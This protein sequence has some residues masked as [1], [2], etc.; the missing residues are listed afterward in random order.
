[1]PQ[2]LV[3]AVLAVPQLAS[4]AWPS[5]ALAALR[6]PDEQLGRSAPTGRLLFGR[7]AR[8]KPPILPLP[9]CRHRGLPS[10]MNA[11]WRPAGYNSDGD[12]VIPNPNPRLTLPLTPTL[13]LTLTRRARTPRASQGCVHKNHVVAPNLASRQHPATVQSDASMDNVQI[14]RR[15]K[16]S[17][18]KH[19][20]R[21]LE[22]E[23]DDT[24]LAGPS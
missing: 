13:T 21:Q 6:T 24:F 12:E 22:R 14:S 17:W 9:T 7:E 3:R 20:G 1:M 2:P 11:R 8:P 15:C 19:H 5:R 23:L 18:S 10:E 16:L 4:L